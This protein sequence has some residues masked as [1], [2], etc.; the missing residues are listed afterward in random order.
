MGF[1]LGW[2]WGIE[3]LIPLLLFEL[4]LASNLVKRLELD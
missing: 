4:R 2:G 3:L 1:T